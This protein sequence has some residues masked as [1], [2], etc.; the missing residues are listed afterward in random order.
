MG[1]KAAGGRFN[2]SRM[3]IFLSQH[4]ARRRTRHGRFFRI[5]ATKNPVTA[6]LYRNPDRDTKTPCTLRSNTWVSQLKTSQ[7]FWVSMLTCYARNVRS[8]LPHQIN[9]TIKFTIC[10]Y[11]IYFSDWIM[12]KTLDFVNMTKTEEKYLQGCSENQQKKFCIFCIY[13]L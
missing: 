4:Y 9:C 2:E 7:T 8:L 12:S 6:I 13:A 11:F 10:Q 5:F 3:G 1:G